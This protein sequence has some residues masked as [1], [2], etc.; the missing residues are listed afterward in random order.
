MEWRRG[1]AESELRGP[2]WIRPQTRG[3]SWGDRERHSSGRAATGNRKGRL[4]GRPF[5]LVE[6]SGAY[7]RFALIDGDVGGGGSGWE[8]V[9]GQDDT[10]EAGW[11]QGRSGE[12]ASV[13]DG[14]ELRWNRQPRPWKD[15]WMPYL[16][17]QP[18]RRL[19]CR[20][21]D[22]ASR[23]S[24]GRQRRGRRRAECRSHRRRTDRR[25]HGERSR[26]CL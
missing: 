24:R 23:W 10:D 8:G 12:E 19:C 2:G 1:E 20:C 5:A 11:N 16:R 18:P 15:R 4:W 25:C 6:D 7:G 26:R 3:D 9:G 22:W 17:H 14:P 21:H 13:G